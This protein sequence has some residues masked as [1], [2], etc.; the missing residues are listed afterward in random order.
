MF[1]NKSW[2]E[3]FNEERS[4]DFSLTTLKPYEEE[5]FR[6]WLPNTSMFKAMK[7][8]IAKQF[9]KDKRDI[10]DEDVM[11]ATVDN[12]NADY[13]Y[14]GA[15]VGGING[16]MG[17][18]DTAN[19]GMKLRA[20]VPHS[21]WQ[22]KFKA[23]VGKSPTDL[24]IDN[25]DDAKVWYEQNAIKT[26]QQPQ[27]PIQTEQPAQ[28]VADKKPMPEGKVPEMM[29]GISGAIRD[30]IGGNYESKTRMNLNDVKQTAP[31]TAPMT[32]AVAT[33]ANRINTAKS[34]NPFK[35]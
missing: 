33:I 27:Q 20:T 11:K 17:M 13:D 29:R 26:A 32:P 28:S 21:Q 19:N 24:G 3:Q 25:I 4:R 31:K 10:K 35:K 15:F 30:K 12:P 16:S 1:S 7:S 6:G 34:F 14:R 8:Q 22:E 23:E 9:G 18:P 5:L 2:L